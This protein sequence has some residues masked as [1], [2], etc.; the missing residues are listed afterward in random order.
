MTRGISHPYGRLVSVSNTAAVDQIAGYDELGR[1]TGS[2]Q[3]IGGGGALAFSYTYNLVDALVQTTYPTGRTVTNSYDAAGRTTGVTGV[4]SGTPTS[5]VSGLAYAPSGAPNGFAYGNNLARAYTYNN[6]L[7]PATITDT[8]A[9]NTLFSLGYTFGTV[10]TNNGNPTQVT[11]GGTGSFTQTF[12]YDALN[13]LN[14]FTDSGGASQTLGYNQYGNMWQSAQTGLGSVPALAS[15]PTSS[16]GVNAANNRLTAAS[17]DIPSGNQTLFL[18]VTLTYD[19]ENHQVQSYNSVSGN[20]YTYAYDGLGARVSKALSGG[21]TTLYL[22]DG[23]GNLAAEYNSQTPAAACLTCYLSG[24]HLGSTRLVTDGSGNVMA[25]HDFLPFGV[26][27]PNGV[28]GRTGS[29]AITDG[30]SPKFTGQD[31]DS[32]TLLEFYQARYLASGLGR[33]MSVDPGNAGADATDP[34]SWN[35]YSY[36]ANRPM[37]YVDPSGMFLTAE[38][39]INDPEA[40][41]AEDGDGWGWGGGGGWWGGR[42]RG[43]GRRFVAA[44]GHSVLMAGAER[45]SG[46]QRPVES[47]CD[48][49][50]NRDGAGPK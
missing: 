31:H 25:R 33:F 47:W 34:Q 45:W 41:E 21:A 12:G 22:H 24:D 11:I 28:A 40:C 32:E 2:S 50:A 19:A 10:T 39:C 18:G 37:V 46:R 36:V 3:A 30:L 43:L 8:L 42:D 1:I 35:M 38:D 13:R 14:G 6:R 29:W 15:M 17:Y 23:F 9:G 49:P 27:I 16:G 7:Q 5:Y 44:A 20:T 48:F 26:E 4:M